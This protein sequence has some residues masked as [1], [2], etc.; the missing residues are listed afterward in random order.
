MPSK[1]IFIIS[2]VILLTCGIIAFI[3]GLN[4]VAAVILAVTGIIGIITG[5]KY[6]PEKR[7]VHKW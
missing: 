5:I 4:V 7:G 1:S 6:S 2:G 3:T